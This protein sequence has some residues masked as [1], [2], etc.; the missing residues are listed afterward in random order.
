MREARFC[1][2]LRLH[3]RFCFFFKAPTLFDD[4]VARGWKTLKLLNK[5]WRVQ[6]DFRHEHRLFA[7]PTEGATF[8]SL[9]DTTAAAAT[10]RDVFATSTSDR[11]P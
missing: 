4:I 8:S 6:A 10:S 3:F 9:V 1:I 7:S 2:D 11:T 5:D